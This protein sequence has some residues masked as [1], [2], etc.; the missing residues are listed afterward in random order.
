MVTYNGDEEKYSEEGNVNLDL[1]KLGKS[2]K[3][4]TVFLLEYFLVM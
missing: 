3:N 4:F 2:W 1:D